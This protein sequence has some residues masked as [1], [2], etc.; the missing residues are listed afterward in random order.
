M[1]RTEAE[2]A[3]RA[4]D[5]L[6]D[7]KRKLEAR[8]KQIE[9]ESL[10]RVSSYEA[11]LKE[12]EDARNAAEEDA[13]KRS[14]DVDRLQ[15]TWDGQR[16]ELQKQI[17]AEKA[18]RAK[19]IAEWQDR[20][21][22][23]AHKYHSNLVERALIEELSTLS[24]SAKAELVFFQKKYQFEA[25]EDEDGRFIGV[26]PKDSDKTIA[27]LHKEICD[28]Y[29]LPFDKN[30]RANGS[31]TPVQSGGESSKTSSKMPANWERLSKEERQKWFAQNRNFKLG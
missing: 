2:E 27:Q 5:K 25:V 28:E 15:K 20:H 18:A 8:L 7:E 29:G 3:F 21:D 1:S 30:D 12:I 9:T 19:E 11:R 31:G 22:G 26:K 14:G 6:K 17:D 24:T 23:L 13:A 4:R 16:S 10:E